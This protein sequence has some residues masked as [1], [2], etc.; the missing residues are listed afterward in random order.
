MCEKTL[1]GRYA[2]INKVKGGV[3]ISLE[4]QAGMSRS[5]KAID[6]DLSRQS[7]LI[8]KQRIKGKLALMGIDR[9]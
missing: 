7:P 3:K 8:G 6:S 9:T 1:R 5:L 4:T 2:K